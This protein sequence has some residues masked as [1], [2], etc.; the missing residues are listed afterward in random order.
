MGKKVSINLIVS[1]EMSNRGEN[2]VVR[3]PKK[4][5]LY[6]GLERGK[7]ILG[8]GSY[9]V[10]AVVRAAYTSDIRRLATLI[11]RGEVL[12]GDAPLVGF[13][14]GHTH[15][16]VLNK[17][18]NDPWLSEK[19]EN[20]TI[21]CDPEFGLIHSN[22]TLARGD[23]V[24][25]N[26]KSKEFGED[27]PGVEVRP[28]PSQNH[29]KLIEN[30]GAI[31]EEPPSEA[32][33]FKWIGGATFS[34][35]ERVY[36]FG[37]HIHFGRPKELK[38]ERAE[39][40]FKAIAHVLDYFIAWPMLTFDTPNPHFRRS[41]CK[42]HYGMAGDIRT[43]A[44]NSRFEYRVLSGL[45]LTHPTLAALTIGSAKAVVEH[46]YSKAAEKDFDPGYVGGIEGVRKSQ[47]L[48]D[49]GISG[50]NTIITQINKG[51]VNP[52]NPKRSSIW[53]DKF[54]SLETYAEYSREVEALIAIVEAS[55]D[56]VV[57]YLDLDLRKNWLEG[58]LLLAQST[59]K[60]R[61]ALEAVE[62]KL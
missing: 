14:S 60:V 27:G 55:P 54:R 28:A 16:L 59:P 9:R 23:C 47:M 34:D 37:G 2:D 31:L 8:K 4:S 56:K 48:K 62:E 1:T 15:N 24:L 61:A 20:I 57:Q 46:C 26:S 18:G 50:L 52:L 35:E 17:S 19:L 33:P 42:Y 30:I 22:G 6:L 51:D 44:G 58:Q 38:V 41:G 49:C 53:A 36:W 32:R 10:E 12:E 11:R 39:N 7:V 25:P 29:L 45:W 40:F 21:G 13:V 5:R 3:L 43:K